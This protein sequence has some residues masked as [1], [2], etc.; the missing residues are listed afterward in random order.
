MCFHTTRTT[1]R[2]SERHISAA[3]YFTL[4]DII[5]LLRVFVNLL[6]QYFRNLCYQNSNFYSFTRIHIQPRTA[7]CRFQVQSR[8]FTS[9]NCLAR[10]CPAPQRST[11]PADGQVIYMKKIFPLLDIQYH[12]NMYRIKRMANIFRTKHVVS[13]NRQH[14]KR[15]C[16][17]SKRR[18]AEAIRRCRVQRF[19]PLIPRR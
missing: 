15:S 6:L 17:N 19:S 13:S 18:M 9:Q 11:A 5:F 16:T 8:I 3:I 14:A 1:L 12:G 10:L 4:H 7:A 2:A